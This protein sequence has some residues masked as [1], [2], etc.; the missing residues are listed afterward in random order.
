M[1]TSSSRRTVECGSR[2]PVFRSSTVCRLRHFATVFW[3]D[4][5]LPA[6]L[7]DRSL[8]SLYCRFGG[9]LGRGATV[10]NLAH[11]ASFHSKEKI[12]PSNSGIK[13]F[14]VWRT[15]NPRTRWP[16]WSTTWADCGGFSAGVGPPDAN[17]DRKPTRRLK[18]TA[19]AGAKGCSSGRLWVAERVIGGVHLLWLPLGGEPL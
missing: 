7:R 8:P 4:A 5:R 6:Q 19:V 18:T 17:A 14:A 11:I 2:G 16:T 1:A 9:V 3:V 13:H 10:T 12:A 15:L